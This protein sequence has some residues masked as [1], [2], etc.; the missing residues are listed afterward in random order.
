MV[1]TIVNPDFTKKTPSIAILCL[2]FSCSFVF[3]RARSFMIG[4]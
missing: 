2:L 1:V 3:L 4:L